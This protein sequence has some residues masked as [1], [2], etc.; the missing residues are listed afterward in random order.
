MRLSLHSA[1]HRSKQGCEFDFT[2]HVGHNQTGTQ[3]LVRVPKQES[4][5]L[6]E[7][8]TKINK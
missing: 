7:P 8:W 1:K 4:K 5:R 6:P 3:H 2:L